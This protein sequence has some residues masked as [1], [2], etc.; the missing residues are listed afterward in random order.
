VLLPNAQF[1]LSKVPS[2]DSVFSRPPSSWLSCPLSPQIEVSLR[3]PVENKT[4]RPL[5][6]VEILNTSVLLSASSTTGA[7]DHG[8]DPA[9]EGGNVSKGVLLAGF[10]IILKLSIQSLVIN[11]HKNKL[12]PPTGAAT[13]ITGGGEDDQET[14]RS[15]PVPPTPAAPLPSELVTPILLS[16]SHDHFLTAC[17]LIDIPPASDSA[18]ETAPAMDIQVSVSA[19]EVTIKKDLIAL[20]VEPKVRAYLA[21]TTY[22]LRKML[23]SLGVL[24]DD[25]LILEHSLDCL[26]V[27]SVMLR[28]L[29]AK[30]TTQ[31][32]QPTN[33]GTGLATVS[34]AVGT[35]DLWTLEM[36]GD[37]SSTGSLMNRHKEAVTS[38]LNTS[39]YYK[40]LC[41]LLPKGVLSLA[42]HLSTI[43]ANLLS[44]TSMKTF[45]IIS[46]QDLF[47]RAL[48]DPNA[49]PSS[50]SGVTYPRGNAL[51]AF[52]KQATKKTIR[53]STK[54]GQR[55]SN[56]MLSSAISLVGKGGASTSMSSSAMAVIEPLS[57]EIKKAT[58]PIPLISLSCSMG[59]NLSLPVDDDT[60]CRGLAL[61]MSSLLPF[62]S[63]HTVPPPETHPQDHEE[64]D[65]EDKEAAQTEAT[66]QQQQRQGEG[67]QGQG[68]RQGDAPYGQQQGSPPVAV[69]GPAEE[70]SAYGLLLE[71]KLPQANRCP[72]N[73][74]RVCDFS[75]FEVRIDNGL[76]KK[77][78]RPSARPLYNPLCVYGFRYTSLLLFLPSRSLSL[79]LTGSSPVLCLHAPPLLLLS[80]AEWIVIYRTL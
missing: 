50:T 35:V 1:T 64:E 10:L 19:L 80:S 66:E 45:L 73:T 22:C 56:S 59:L 49:S 6:S 4:R 63:I 57:V 68:L 41:S 62:Y 18:A 32:P 28:N 15:A 7:H 75:S 61:L 70:S 79:V 37:G 78:K 8:N 23:I 29:R 17:V 27:P 71:S 52:L 26:G 34:T 12:L 51:N 5:I 44:Q 53:K 14:K 48:S 67:E 69:S 25:S 33:T 11:L 36:D 39:R 77:E 40:L 13:G 9:A 46:M 72:W 47:D 54:I 30:M 42:L 24:L 76:F 38:Y 31:Q 65:D 43:H 74:W 3:L 60:I 2:P 58:D 20:L 21:Q 16:S 55:M